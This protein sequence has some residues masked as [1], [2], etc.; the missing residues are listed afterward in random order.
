MTILGFL[1]KQI[2][3][4]KWLFI[5]AVVFYLLA[6]TLVQL[7]PLVIQQAIDG[8][9]T[10]L[11]KGL[12][13]DE[14]VFLT[15]SAQYMGMTVLGAIGFYLSMR[16]LMHCAN[17]IAENLRKQA[18]DVMQRLPI[19]FFDDKPAGKIATR[20]VNDTE[21]LRT[22]FYGTL[23]YAFNNIVRLVFTYAVLFYMNRSLGWLMLLLIPL[24]IGI[25]FAYKKMTDKPM[26]DFY[27]ARSDV[28]TQVNE[29]MNGASLIQLFGQEERSMQE[30]EAT[31]DKMRRA[32]NKMIWAQSLATW[33]LSGFLQN[34][35]I[36]G[37]LTVVGYQFLKGHPGV[38]P[39]R[40]FVYVNY[41]EGIFIALGALV[42]QFPNMLRSF[43]TGKRLM[44]LLEEEAEPD[45]EH[46]LEVNQGQVVF[47]NV[48]FS[49][50]ENKPVL[51][52]I[53]IRAEKGET[54]ALVGHTGSG[55]SSIMNLLYR[56]YDPQAGRVLID[57]KNIRDYSRESLRSHMGIVLQDPYLFTGTIASNV[58][59]NEETA[60]KTRI[61][62]SLEKV[63]AGPM[64]SRL[65][66]GIDEPV[67]EKGAAF[68]SGERQ[69]IAFA[70]TLYSDPKILILDEATSHIDTETEEIIQHAME[71]VKEGRTTFI[72]AH[73][74]ST[75]Q[76]ADQIFVLDQ[77]RIIEHGKH[78]DLIAFGGTYSQMHEIQARV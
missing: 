49:Y 58:S 27:D 73:R 31:A 21:T 66:K 36:T 48:N 6:S 25:Q 51:R 20:I 61:L 70:R 26:K 74:L 65:E 47:E 44:A 53:S 19:S 1:L 55:K 72:I 46:D 45:S 30:F 39:G 3:R 16:L 41:I 69:L 17:R 38:T 76:N 50:E 52:D 23:V 68:S 75:I 10:D 67:V 63:G 11:S 64:L 60:D 4:I 9:I 71:V 2:K 7:A 40:L 32:D 77:G 33:N 28:N 8:P 22:Q 78:E 54:V 12:P 57:G 18:Y 5:V 42:Q 14:T 56:F 35:V 29:T 15:Q 43:E 59:M 13:F 24:Y 62:Q 37:I 34:L